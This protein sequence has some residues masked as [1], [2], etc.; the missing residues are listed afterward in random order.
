MDSCLDA[1]SSGNAIFNARGWVYEL[2]HD[3]FR[4]LSCK[5]GDH[6]RMLSRSSRD[7][8]LQFP[9]MIVALR[10]VGY[11]FVIDASSSSLTNEGVPIGIAFARV[12]RCAT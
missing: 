8:F 7:M 4:C 11:D 2:K 9:D 3:G 10:A 6:V 5:V 12:Q 1:A